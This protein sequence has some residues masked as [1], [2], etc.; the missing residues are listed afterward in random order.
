MS[1]NSISKTLTPANFKG[2]STS[3]NGLYDLNEEDNIGLQL[4]ERKRR[5][6]DTREVGLEDVEMGQRNTIL[7]EGHNQIGAI[8]S[9]RDL[10]AP[11]EF[12]KTELALQASRAQ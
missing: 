8:I 1:G 4:E 7:I 11:T 6:S 3:S 5:R 10:S 2:F 9:T 12:A